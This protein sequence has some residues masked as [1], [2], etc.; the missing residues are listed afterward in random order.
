MNN[1][2]QPSKSIQLILVVGLFAILLTIGVTRC[3]HAQMLTV[4]STAILKGPSDEQDDLNVRFSETGLTPN[5]SIQYQITGSAQCANGASGAVG[6]NFSLPVNK[7]GI[8][9]NTITV[10]EP[11]GCVGAPSYFNMQFCD[12]TNDL[13]V[14]F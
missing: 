6:A 7:R 8:A 2:P 3:A 12:V 13:C 14:G 4:K 10:E 1:S 11:G 5:A 9:G